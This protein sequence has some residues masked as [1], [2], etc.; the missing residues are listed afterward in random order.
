MT[1]TDKKAMGRAGLT[2]PPMRTARH[3]KKRGHRRGWPLTMSAAIMA[4]GAVEAVLEELL[5]LLVRPPPGTEVPA[6]D[7][8]KAVEDNASMQAVFKTVMMKEGAL[9]EPQNQRLK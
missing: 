5:N 1:I 9:K 4:A 6:G 7:I 3:L 2:V 8:M